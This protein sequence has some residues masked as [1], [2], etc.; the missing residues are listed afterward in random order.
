L[1]LQHTFH[2]NLNKVPF[3]GTLSLSVSHGYF[4]LLLVA[5]DSAAPAVDAPHIP[6]STNTESGE[7]SPRLQNFP[8][9]SGK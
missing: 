5:S 2:S 3:C 4:F 6:L 8:S 9:T 1:F 7:H